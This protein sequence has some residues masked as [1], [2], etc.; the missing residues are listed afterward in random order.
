MELIEHLK[1]SLQ[2][3]RQQAA[4]G[5]GLM[6][7]LAQEKLPAADFQL[8]ADSIP[9]ISDI[10][11]KAPI[12]KHRRISRL[13]ASVSRLIG[14]LGGLAPLVGPFRM[15]GLD[16]SMLKKFAFLLI[17]YFREKGGDQLAVILQ[18]VWT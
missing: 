16:K 17:E 2:I 1:Q 3:T 18:R 10:I 12:H 6:L 9:A 15:L 4:G 11:G 7:E 13:R 5:A 14:G 8:V